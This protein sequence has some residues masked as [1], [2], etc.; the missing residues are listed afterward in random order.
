MINLDHFDLNLRPL[1]LKNDLKMI[2]L[3]INDQFDQ[4]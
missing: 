1:G 4:I 3:I 2:I